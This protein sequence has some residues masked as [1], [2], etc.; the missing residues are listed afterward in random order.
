M[1]TASMVELPGGRGVE[2]LG[3]GTRKNGT[4][5]G[6]GRGTPR[7]WNSQEWNSQGAGGWNSQGVEPARVKFNLLGGSVSGTRKN[8]IQVSYD[9]GLMRP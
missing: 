3:G 8:E 1:A 6:Q 9:K 2:L 4:P 5:R 7:E